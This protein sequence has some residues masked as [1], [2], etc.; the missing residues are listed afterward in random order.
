M[1]VYNDVNF[2][3]ESIK[4]ILTQTYKNFEFIIS[5][6]CSTDGSDLICK[7]YLIKDSRIRYIRQPKNL[8]ISK[9]MEFLLKRANTKYF[10]WAGDDDILAPTFIETLIKSIENNIDSISAFCTFSSINEK[11]NI[12]T[13]KQNFDY[14]NSNKL[15]RLSN[16]IRNSNDTFGYG[17]FI[18]NEIKKVKFPVWWWP[19]KKCPYNNIFPSLCF[20]LAKGNYIH[21]YG[22]PLFFKR[23]KSKESSNYRTPFSSNGLKDSFAFFLRRFYLVCFSTKMIIKGGGIILASLFFPKLIIYWFFIPSWKQIKMAFN[24]FFHSDN[25]L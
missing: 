5:D 14:S 12:T 9:N 22:E 25:L 19:N 4:S 13:G 3:E 23:E 2:I 11:G 10:M 16:F 18:T 8:G 20:Y 6:D 15:K 24:S 21:N 17:I 1:P 7:K